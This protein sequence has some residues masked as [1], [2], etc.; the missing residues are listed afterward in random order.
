MDAFEV[1]VSIVF[2]GLPVIFIIR[3]W[4]YRKE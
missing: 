3:N 1:C 2:L 4:Y